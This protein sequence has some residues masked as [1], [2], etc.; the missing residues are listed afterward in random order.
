MNY[1]KYIFFP[2][3]LLILS[4]TGLSHIIIPGFIQDFFAMELIPTDFEFLPNFYPNLEKLHGPPPDHFAAVYPYVFRLKPPIKDLFYEI[5]Q[6]KN[7]INWTIN[8]YTR[9]LTLNNVYGILY[10][11]TNVY[12][13]CSGAIITPSHEID[14]PIVGHNGGPPSIYKFIEGTPKYYAPK[15][16]YVGHANIDSYDHFV[17]DVLCPL[18]IM[19]EEAF[20]DS[21]IACKRNPFI[22]DY[23]KILGINNEVI[24]LDDKDW[25]RT[26]YLFYAGRPRPHFQHSGTIY[27]KLGEKIRK[28]LGLV[29]VSPDRYILSNVISPRRQLYNMN[30]ALKAVQVNNPRF[31]WEIYNVDKQPLQELAKVWGHARILFSVYGSNLVNAFLFAKGSVV[32]EML[33]DTDYYA[34]IDCVLASQA[35]LVVFYD[36]SFAFAKEQKNF[37]KINRLL[38]AVKAAVG[39]LDRKQWLND[40][41]GSIFSYKAIEDWN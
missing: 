28:K 35:K 21:V 19:P 29:N 31:N 20:K 12:V 5:K 26:P 27:M 1:N 4:V 18:S 2:L 34:S 23:L 10:Q 40:D 25:V 17:L 22:K 14:F 15:T 13:S 8:P 9:Y 11:I 33:G 7:T 32:I 3:A 6:G 24:M 36:N 41:E 37:V 38:A 30:E 39:Y 16:I